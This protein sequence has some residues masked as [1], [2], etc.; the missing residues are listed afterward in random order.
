M[1]V[2]IGCILFVGMVLALCTIANAGVT[3]QLYMADGNTPLLYNEIM[4]GTRLTVYIES[5]EAMEEW[6]GGLYIE[7]G[8]QTI[9]DVNGLLFGRGEYD[10]MA[11]SYTESPLPAAGIGAYAYP[12]L[13]P[14][15]VITGL[16]FGT[17][18]TGTEIGRWFAVDYNAVSVGNCGFALYK[19]LPTPPF[20]VTFLQRVELTHV[21]TRD[22]NN[23]AVVGFGDFAVLGYYWQHTDCNEQ[24][25]WCEGADLDI[26][27][28]VDFND[29]IDFT[30]YWLEKLRQ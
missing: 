2:R 5:D 14:G 13:D 10:P 17:G 27:G 29:I 6:Y 30:D 16:G 18:F 12:V 22:F 15:A 4:V 24:N 8:S 11:S 20:T 26:N 25:G 21:R 28:S 3:A 7:D 19:E 23:D 1:N 9:E